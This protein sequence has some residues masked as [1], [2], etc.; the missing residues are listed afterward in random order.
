[1]GTPETP[2]PTQPAPESSSPV[3]T[4]VDLPTG[5]PFT[6]VTSSEILRATLTPVVLLVGSAKCG[7]TTLLA[8]L[9][10][11]FQRGLSFAGYICAGSQ[12]LMGFEERCFDSRFSSGGDKPTTLRTRPADGLW[13]YHLKLRDEDLATASR[14]LL[15]GDMSGELYDAA[16][17]SAEEMRKH[18]IIRRADHFVHL[19]DAG[20]LSSEEYRAYTRANAFLL[21]RRCLEENMFDRDAKVDVL[22][23]KWDIAIAR[24]GGEEKA[25]EFLKVQQEQIAKQWDGKIGQLRIEAVAARPHYKS[26]L[27]HG[28]GLTPFLRSWVDE[29]PRQS[30][31]K[32]VKFPAV[33]SDR[34]FDSFAFTE[35]PEMFMD[36]DNV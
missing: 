20:R 8:S 29:P 31:P 35:V 24:C 3:V 34:M 13:F 22:L 18:A 7:K 28:F 27:K 10:D 5:K 23:T 11:S 2:T 17:N 32:M 4:D 1:M 15:V 33:H 12:T 6:N 36:A 9:H 30:T 16:V 26:H 19:I 14:H 25:S 21:I